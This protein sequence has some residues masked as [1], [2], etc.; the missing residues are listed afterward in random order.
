MERLW[1]C[2]IR[3]AEG[4]HVFSHLCMALGEGMGLGRIGMIEFVAE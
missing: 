1:Q 2:L 4:A 3:A